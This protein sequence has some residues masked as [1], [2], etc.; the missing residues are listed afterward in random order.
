MVTVNIFREHDIELLIG[1]ISSFCL[2]D[3]R[4]P[5]RPERA[6]TIRP[7][8]LFYGVLSEVPIKVTLEWS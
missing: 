3:L 2:L 4:S 7:V 1:E 5:D 6:V 8:Q